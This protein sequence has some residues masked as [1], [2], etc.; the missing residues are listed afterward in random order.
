VSLLIVEDEVRVA[1]FLVKG[2][3]AQ[4]YRV[5]HVT[6][7]ED[8]LARAESMKFSLVILDLGLPDL[9][10]LE[11]LRR[12][13]ENGNPT[14]VIILTARTEMRDRARS[15]ELGADD[16]VTKPFVFSDLLERLR[17]HLVAAGDEQA[18]TD[19]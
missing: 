9:D 17:I 1:M 3:R 14:P 12:L 6:T 16:F 7:G 4:G 19:K 15:F 2:L 8:A 18:G 11:V 10:G 5:D 13:R